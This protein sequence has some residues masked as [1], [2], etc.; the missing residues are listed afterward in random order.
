M[1]CLFITVTVSVGQNKLRACLCV[2]VH[3]CFCVQRECMSTCQRTYFQTC[4]S[5]NSQSVRPSSSHL[6][7][8]FQSVL[9]AGGG[10]SFYDRDPFKVRKPGLQVLN[11]KPAC[12]LSTCLPP[13]NP[14]VHFSS[15]LPSWRHPPGAHQEPGKGDEREKSPSLAR[16]CLPHTLVSQRAPPP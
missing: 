14:R 9:S 6:R 3:A 15:L 5:A 13:Q 1:C 12:F 8:L 4:T 10:G 7:C 2:C 11:W 16:C